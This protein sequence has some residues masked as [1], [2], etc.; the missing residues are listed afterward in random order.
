[1]FGP[2][3]SDLPSHPAI[4]SYGVIGT[5]QSLKAFESFSARIR[6]PIVDQENQVLWPPF[7]G[8]DVAFQSLLPP[9]PTARCIL[10]AEMLTAECKYADPLARVA[11]VVERYLQ[12]IEVMAK[13]DEQIHV[14]ICLV[15]DEVYTSCRSLSGTPRAGHGRVSRRRT[16]TTPTGQLQLFQ[17][18]ETDEYGLSP[19]FRRQLKARA[20]KFGIPIQIIRE[21]TLCLPNIGPPSARRLTPLS[22]RAWKLGVALYYKAGGKPWRLA[23]ARPGVCYIGL[24]YKR[25]TIDVCSN[26]ACCAA[27]VFLDSGDGIVF[28]GQVGPWYSPRN[29]ECHLSADAAY[30]LMSGVLETYSEMEG[31]PLTEVFLHCRSSISEEEF[32]GFRKACPERVKLVG[33]RV[34]QEPEIRL[35]R[36]GCWPVLRGTLWLSSAREAYLWTHGYK[37]CLQTY[38]GLEVPV[39]LRITIQHGDADPIQVASDI[40]GLTKLN[41]NSCILGDAQPVTIRFSDAVGDVLVGNPAV[42]KRSHKF[43]FYI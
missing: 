1:M 19:D 36:E 13:R 37:P 2:Y 6:C 22:D 3:D 28:M 10:D 43:K 30:D 5:P 12:A 9:Q 20:M 21:S 8:F 29:K 25:T 32:Q 26:T 23:S 11:A 15:P 27:Q 18:I 4:I 14:I 34:K 7:P 33:I 31:Q 40:L 38:D 16:P 35:Y 24:A 17:S 42:N 41:Y 39:P